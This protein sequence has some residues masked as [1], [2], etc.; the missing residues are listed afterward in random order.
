MA[1][2]VDRNGKVLVRV[3]KGGVTRSK[4]FPNKTAARAW[5]ERLE[6]EISKAGYTG[7]VDVRSVTVA[8]MIDKYK[9]EI[10]PDKPHG[11]SKEFSINLIRD[12]LGRV[13]LGN[14]TSRKVIEFADARAKEGAGP[15]T[16][17]ADIAYLG[18]MLR[19]ARAVWQWDLSDQI[20]PDALEALRLRGLVGKSNQRDRRITAEEEKTLLAYFKSKNN[21]SVPMADMTLFLIDTAMRVSE[22]TRITWDDLN[23][24]DKT[25]LIRDRKH[26]TEKIGNNTEVPL[27]GRSYEIAALQPQSSER[28]FPYNPKT[29]G[30][31]WRI[32][33]KK[34]GIEDLRLHDLRHEG[35]SRLFEAGYSIPQVRLVSG[36]RDVNMLM[37]YTQL[38]A[39]DLHRVPV[40]VLET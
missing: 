5:A 3:R 35:I 11:R 31:Y 15:V 17:A 22:A 40:P 20:I 34:C 33:C 16:V 8:D 9:A 18:G 27:L 25:I 6:A 2:L 30:T 13:R 38:K 4:T 21:W 32:A 39:K 10:A 14:L 12:R 24:E 26:P 23:R 28:I 37:R 36:H 1:T 19:I 7:K 29:V